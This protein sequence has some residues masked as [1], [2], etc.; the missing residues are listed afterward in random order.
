MYFPLY[1]DVMYL[2]WLNQ[3]GLWSVKRVH[4]YTVLV[5]IYTST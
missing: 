5:F 3:H 4:I 2:P 1:D